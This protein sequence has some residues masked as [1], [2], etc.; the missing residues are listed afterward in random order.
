MKRTDW[1]MLEYLIEKD[2]QHKADKTEKNM[3]ESLLKN[4]REEDEHPEWY[5]GW[6]ECYLCMSYGD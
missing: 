4:T 5:E 6:C 1:E 3:L 2:L